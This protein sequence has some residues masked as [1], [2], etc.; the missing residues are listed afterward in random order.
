MQG[1]HPGPS[2]HP[3][4]ASSPP[5]GGLG[6]G[7]VGIGAK[8]GGA[9]AGGREEAGPPSSTDTSVIRAHPPPAL[10]PS[11]RESLPPPAPTPTPTLPLRTDQGG[12]HADR[13]TFVLVYRS[14]AVR[15]SFWALESLAPHSHP[16]LPTLN[17]TW[18][19]TDSQNTRVGRGVPRVVPRLHSQSAKRH[20]SPESPGSLQSPLVY[21]APPSMAERKARVWAGAPDPAPTQELGA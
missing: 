11:H 12:P 3:A 16:F 13:F 20:P 17:V 10:T 21:W 2:R 14:A 7:W 4:Q 18:R 5:P 19:V 1:K 6:K 15:P 9:G 8:A